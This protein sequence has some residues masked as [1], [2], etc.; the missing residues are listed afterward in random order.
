M[1]RWGMV[2]DLD[3]C[4]G[5]QA[6]SVACKE[7]NNVPHGSPEEQQWMREIYWHKVIAATNGRYPRVS[8]QVI[9]MPCMHCD[10]APCVTVC[11]ARA[12][13]RREDGIV[14]QNF[15][16]CLGCKY[17]MV[18][19]PYGARSFNYK[20]QEEEEYFHLDSPPDRSVWGQWPYPTRTHGVVE[21]CTFC[22][23]RI[24]KGLKEGKKIGKDVVPACVEACPANARA[25][26]DLDDTGSEVSR[27][28]STRR[29]IRLRE[30]LDT[31][32]KVYYL[33]K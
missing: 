13:Y 15:R 18:A 2:I 10:H 22:F 24:D 27:L 19:C 17:C 31:K 25:F 20:E 8:T 3:K 11:P 28:L 9:P 33:L 6:C 21:K 12:T 26:G 30:E 7:E 16:R 4:V 14:I 23:H 32:C 5:C 1:P 29:P